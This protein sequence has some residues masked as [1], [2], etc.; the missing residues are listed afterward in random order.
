[1]KLLK[2]STYQTLLNAN[3]ELSAT[4]SSLKCNLDIV[5]DKAI[6]LEQALIELE[7]ERLYVNFTRDKLGRLHPIKSKPKK[8][9]PEEIAKKYLGSKITID[10]M[11]GKVCGCNRTDILIGLDNNLGHQAFMVERVTKLITYQSYW[12]VDLKEVKKQLK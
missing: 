6:K 10:G 3:S 2:N 11:T 9:T 7:T 5:S 4:N 8:G 1:M 12:W